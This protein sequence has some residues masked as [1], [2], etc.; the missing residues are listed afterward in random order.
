[1]ADI[2]IYTTQ[3]CPYCVKAKDLLKKK[4]L[5]SYKEIDVSG[6]DILREEMVKKANG[7]RTVPQ[8]FIN[9]SHVGGCDNLY[10]LDREGK[11]DQLVAS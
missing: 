10:Q 9:G 4:G 6:N 7:L 11:L 5:T 2:I 1:M 3:T 8:I